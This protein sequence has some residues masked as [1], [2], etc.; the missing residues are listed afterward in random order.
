MCEILYVCFVLVFNQN[1]NKHILIA[2]NLV[3]P[4]SLKAKTKWEREC[5]KSEGA[6]ETRQ[7]LQFIYGSPLKEFAWN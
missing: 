1:N 6:V 4:L 7:L 5:K 2:A 3:W